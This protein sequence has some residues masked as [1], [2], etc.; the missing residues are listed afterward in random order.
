[1]EFKKEVLKAVLE[2]VD[3][4]CDC[5]GQKDSDYR[6]QHP[7]DSLSMVTLEGVINDQ[8]QKSWICETCYLKIIKQFKI[9]PL[10]KEYIWRPQPQTKQ[11]HINLT[12]EWHNG[13]IIDDPAE[14]I[15]RYESKEWQ[16][17]NQS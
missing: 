10:V 16:E 1:M 3:I 14:G 12:N 5:C 17:K 13:S 4:S 8:Q 2:T 11:M 15:P 6:Q 9:M 7:G